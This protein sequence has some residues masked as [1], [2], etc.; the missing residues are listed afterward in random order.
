MQLF[1]HYFRSAS[2]R[3]FLIC[4]L[5]F[6]F[7]MPHLYPQEQVK[8][9]D[10]KKLFF[11]AEDHFYYEDYREAI[12]L[13]TKLNQVDPEDQAYYT[14]QIGL[15]YLYSN[16]DNSRTIPYLRSAADDIA[17]SEIADLYYYHLGRAYHHNNHFDEAIDAYEIALSVEIYDDD[18][19][20]EL[21][22][23]IEMCNNGKELIQHPI[24]VTIK[25]VGTHVNSNYPDYKPVITFNESKLLF[26]SRREGNTGEKIVK[27]GGIFED[28]FM[29]RRDDYGN[30]TPSEKISDKINTASHEASITMSVD[31]QYFFLY[32]GDRGGGNLYLSQLIDEEWTKPKSLGKNVNT[33]YWET[34]AS[35]SADGKSLY[36]TSDRRKGMG[37]R[38]IYKSE[39]Q[40]DG[41]WGPAENLGNLINT[42]YDEESPFIMPDGKTLYFS[43]QGHNSMGGFDIFKSV[44]ENDS[45][46]VPENIGYPLNTAADEVHFIFTPSERKGYYTSLKPGGQGEADVYEVTFTK[47]PSRYALVRG[48]I[49]AKD[50]PATGNTI[51]TVFDSE[52]HGQME[53]VYSPSPSS[54][55]YLLILPKGRKYDLIIEASGY[56]AQLLKLE[57]DEQQDFYELYQKIALKPLNQAGEITGQEI[58]VAN[59]FFDTK[60][61]FNADHT[62]SDI[63][64]QVN[65]DYLRTLTEQLMEITGSLPMAE[66]ESGKQAHPLLLEL[67]EKIFTMTKDVPAVAIQEIIDKKLYTDLFSKEFD[68][69]D[70]ATQLIAYTAGKQTKNVIPPNGSPLIATKEPE[71][72]AGTEIPS[73][74][75]YQN[76]IL[77]EFNNSAISIAYQKD[78][79]HI[80]A[81][82]S[83]SPSSKIEIAGHAD[84][85]GS[86][87]YNMKLSKRRANAVANYLL[88][89]GLDKSKVIVN[90]YGETR[91]L[92]NG[93]SDDDMQMNR[94]TELLI[95][96]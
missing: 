67:K 14:Y 19:K 1:V 49:A 80:Y 72:K 11:K 87:D 52:S 73:E 86:D 22:R 47:E 58:V 31:G 6:F 23:Q 46:S 66:F 28:V 26:T 43:S 81:L 13:Y 84:T 88:N 18:L 68:Y 93:S 44:Y 54:G 8:N 3:L 82:L 69:T 32:K 57:I 96:D 61:P 65:R 71:I 89:K 40:P 38:D 92:T 95:V 41:E 10:I 21:D 4:F 70:P 17:K 36:F 15:C 51:I 7:A 24:D 12:A 27:A 48:S 35:L 5:A 90:A 20:D 62:L 30:W 85:N 56:K 76:T 45:W 64:K 37:R 2:P 74:A 79:N 25:S 91:P 39:L 94:R 42:Q 83:T 59:S 16:I 50:A 63:N 78:L 77:F 53:Y 33:R 9:K 55:E 34:S 75:D 60:K 29:S